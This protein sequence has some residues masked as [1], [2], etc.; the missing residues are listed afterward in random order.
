MGDVGH[1]LFDNESLDHVVLDGRQEDTHIERG[2]LTLQREGQHRWV[3]YTV[4]EQEGLFTGVFI[5]GLGGTLGDVQEILHYRHFFQ[6]VANQKQDLHDASY[7]VPQEPIAQNGDLIEKE[8][9]VGGVL[10][11]GQLVDLEGVDG[12][13][14]VDALGEVYFAVVA[15]VMV[16]DQGGNGHS[17]QVD[18]QEILHE[19]VLVDP[20]DAVVPCV[21]VGRDPLG[22]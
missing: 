18:V 2:L 16:A 19:V 3:I 5:M 10:V 9:G 11:I 6:V 20:L 21:E 7:L 4:M 22:L 14:V 1:E 12:S 17:H 13:D 15:E 8:T